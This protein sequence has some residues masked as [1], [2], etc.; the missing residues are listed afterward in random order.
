MSFNSGHLPNNTINGAMAIMI[1]TNRVIST[2][3]H[4]FGRAISDEF[5]SAFL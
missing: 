4:M 1:I 3:N 5:P 2:S